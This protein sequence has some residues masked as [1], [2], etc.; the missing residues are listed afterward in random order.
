MKI[1]ITGNAGSGKTTLANK[2]GKA[3]DLPVSSL[4]GVVWKEGWVIASKEERVLGEQ[5][6]MSSSNSWVI[7]GVSRVVRNNSVYIV[8]LDV[9]RSICLFRCIKRNLP[10]L[11]KSR[12]ELPDNCPEVL[13]LPKLLK[14]I[15]D[16]PTIA[17]QSILKSFDHQK[18]I[19]IRG[20]IQVDDLVTKIVADLKVGEK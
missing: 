10:Y 16:F 18:G 20:S 17:R 5:E 14:L 1:H 15:W 9:P 3:L 4:D 2:L 13:I 7:E 8:F 12:P 11:F 19:V 6:L